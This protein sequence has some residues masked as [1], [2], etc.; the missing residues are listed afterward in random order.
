MEVALDDVLATLKH[1]DIVFA[2]E[3]EADTFAKVQGIE[4]ASRCDIAQALAQFEKSNAT[5][6]IAVI[7]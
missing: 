1:A 7:T 6:R 3:D 4:G 2:N 5:P